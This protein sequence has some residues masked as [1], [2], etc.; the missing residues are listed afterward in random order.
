MREQ[1]KSKN[2]SFKHIKGTLRSLNEGRGKY[3][4]ILL[5]VDEVV[6]VIRVIGGKLKE[7]DVVRKVLRMFPMKYDSKVSTL[8]ERYDLDQVTVD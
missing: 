5:R 8:E 7:K 4:G 1:L 6:N 2:P 3:W